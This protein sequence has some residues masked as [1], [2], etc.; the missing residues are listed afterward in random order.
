MTLL[1]I[2]VTAVLGHLDEL[3]TQRPVAA[4]IVA[5]SN[6]DTAG[7]AEL[8]TML[9]ADLAL[10]AKVMRLAN[11]AYFGLT[12]KITS[13]PFAVTVV[14]FN[15]VRSIATVALAG[16]DD[17]KALPEGFWDGSIHLAAAC[18]ALGPQFH[19]KAADALCLG[20]LAQL[21]AALLHHADTEEYDRLL[22]RTALGEERFVAETARYGLCAPQLTAAALEHWQFSDTMVTALRE[23]PSGHEGALVRTC[24][25]LAGRLVDPRHRRTPLE[26]LSRRRV[27]ESQAALQIDRIRTDVADLRSALGM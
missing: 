19:T 23:V 20:L 2:D 24:Y 18:G 6:S 8:A 9:G 11:S 1:G 22:A 13:L 26:R 16:V 10:A 21:G 5:T 7:A 12:G 17:A 27:T 25:E 4:R 3:A 14:G 15:T